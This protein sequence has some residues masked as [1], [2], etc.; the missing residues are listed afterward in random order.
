MVVDT[1]RSNKQDDKVEEFADA[2][3]ESKLEG[4]GNAPKKPANQNLAMLSRAVGFN[5]A[6]IG[7]CELQDIHT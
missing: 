6:T 1:S 4:F 2:C 3:D 5:I 7:S